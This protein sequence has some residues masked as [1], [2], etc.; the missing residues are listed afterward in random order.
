MKEEVKAGV[1]VVASLVLLSAFVI[2]IGGSHVFEKLDRYYINVTNAAGLETGAQVRLGGVRVG[3]V[4]DIREP[5]GP[6]RPVTIIIGVR[7][8]TSIFRGTRAVVTQVGFVGDIYLLL[9]VDNTTAEVIGPGGYIP[10][11][12]AA[13]FGMMMAKLDGLSNSVDGLVRDAR[14]LFSEANV[15]QFGRLLRN[16]DRAVVSGSS[17]IEKMAAGL[18]DSS[19]KLQAVLEEV[20]DLV[21]TN[22]GDI[23]QLVKKAKEDLDRADGMI[24]SLEAMA[25]S[26]DRT[27]GSV[28][29]AVDIQSR[30]LDAL[31]NAM[32]KTTE[33]LQDVLQEIRRKP[34]S[35]LYRERKEE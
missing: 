35:V 21:R 5:S 34:W 24:G 8:G 1:T 12:E 4:L 10:S 22:K 3:R 25:R 7:H 2:L 15:D 13:D 31:L 6:G 30:N 18:R 23:S 17:N 28:D 20:E 14:R 9:A 33:D 27:T 26:V 11:R 29:R 32:T 19:A 16:T